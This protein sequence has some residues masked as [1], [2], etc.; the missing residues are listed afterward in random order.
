[1][2]FAGNWSDAPDDASDLSKNPSLQEMGEI[3]A[4]DINR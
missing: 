2:K 4:N 1:M 3:A